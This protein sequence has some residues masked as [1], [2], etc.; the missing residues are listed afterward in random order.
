MSVPAVTKAPATSMFQHPCDFKTQS[1]KIYRFAGKALHSRF[2]RCGFVVIQHAGGQAIMGNRGLFC[3]CSHSRICWQAFKPS[4]CGIWISINTK[5]NCWCCMRLNRFDAV[6]HSDHL[7]TSSLQQQFQQFKVLWNIISDQ[8]RSAQAGR[9]HNLV[10]VQHWLSPSFS[11]RL[12]SKQLP[13]PSVL[14]TVIC[15][16]HQ[17]DRLFTDGGAKTCAA[18]TTAHGGVGLS[19]G[20]KN[21]W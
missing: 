4:K 14:C 18:K 12:N 6:R 21:M 7:M 11:G 5:S 1:G 10:A 2:L 8:H 15:A 3:C 9:V 19:K 13:S 20:I 17:F 16:A